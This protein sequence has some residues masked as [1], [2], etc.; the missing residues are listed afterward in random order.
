MKIR[1]SIFIILNFIFVLLWVV[2]LFTIQILDP[3]NFKDTIEIRQNP[4]KKIIVAE[5][6]NIYD[7]NSELLVSS[8]K[9]YQIDIDKNAILK[10]CKRNPDKKVSKIYSSIASIVSNY[11][12]ISKKKIQQKLNKINRYTSVLISD[13]ITE[14]QLTKIRSDFKEKRI[15]GLVINFKK[16]RRS[17]PKNKLAASLL[18]MIRSNEEENNFDTRNNFY[19]L[20]GVCGIES[21]FEKELS[22]KFGW[23]ETIYDANN[24]RIPFLFLKEKE[25][26]NGNSLILTIDC[27]IQEILEENLENGLETFKANKAIGIIMEPFSGEIIAM[28]GIGKEDINK[29]AAILRAMPN[30]ATS[31]MFEPGSTLKPVTALLALERNIY[32]STDKIDCR[33]YIIEDRTIKDSHEYNFLSFKD[34][35]AYSSNV[36]ISKIVD[37]I[38]SEVLYERLIAMGCGQKTGSNLAG[39]ASGIFRKLKEWQGYSL[40]SISFGQE[41][42]VTAL[43]L[44]NMYCTFANNGNVM[45]PYL[46]KEIRDQKDN[47]IRK[48]GPKILRS[49]SDKNS[50]DT[51]KVFLK[52]V[53]DYGTGVVT[54][55]NYLE[56]AGKTGTAEKI[57]KGETTYSKEKYIS[58]FVGFFPVDIPKYVIVI[59]FDEPD[60]DFHYAS[61][62]T[63]PIFRNIVKKIISRPESDIIVD[64]KQGKTEYNQMPDIIGKTKQQVCEILRKKNILYNLVLKDQDGLVVNQY[65]QP[66][67][68]FDKTEK[69]IV[70]LD[71]EHNQT[72]V[73]ALDYVMPNLQGLTVRKALFEAV[74]KNIKLIISGNGIIVSQSIPPGKKIKFGEICK[75]KAKL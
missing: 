22:G 19:K 35:I 6:G 52:N 34:I 74:K 64:T 30:L 43:Q 68:A 4:S 13:N 1:L 3:F 5:R 59:V 8:I 14:S 51:L 53:V 7:R 38:G 60:Y 47:I 56:I 32:S 36:G 72:E 49:I 9:Y 21:T 75:I 54:K 45:Q 33:N 42:S 10:H 58:V 73:E 11:T 25:A 27:N 24:K 50:L 23:Q 17:Y 31:F 12:D 16:Y 70:I 37:E 46:I 48:F 44:A 65:P 61:S 28:A 63:V 40:H 62:S 66:K 39:E 15:P 41:I 18:G 2:Y 29:S 67:V 69:V 20:Y 71:K 57:I 55:I 26:Q